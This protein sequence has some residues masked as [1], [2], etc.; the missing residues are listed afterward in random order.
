MYLVKSVTSLLLFLSICLNVLLAGFLKTLSQNGPFASNS[1]FRPKTI[2]NVAIIKTKSTTFAFFS[3]PPFL[4]LA[5]SF[6]FSFPFPSLLWFCSFSGLRNLHF[7]P[8]SLKWLQILLGWFSK[9]PLDIFWP[10]SGV[11]HPEHSLAGFNLS[12]V[13]LAGCHRSNAEYRKSTYFCLDLRNACVW[14]SNM[15]S[16]NGFPIDEIWSSISQ[17]PTQKSTI[18][19]EFF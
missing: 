14:E 9:N 12:A 6:F 3:S 15:E 4:L 11:R 1:L 5:L 13:E 19:W 17:K 16:E 10:V 7:N 8:Y 18:V 2:S